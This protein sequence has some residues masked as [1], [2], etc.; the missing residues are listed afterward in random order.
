MRMGVHRGGVLGK[1]HS[2]GPSLSLE[3]GSLRWVGFEFEGRG[4]PMSGVRA[5]V[6]KA[7][8]MCLRALLA[9]PFSNA[10]SS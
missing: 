10:R 4:Q 9:S 5:G 3:Q 6:L 8:P 7:H 1:A 2:R